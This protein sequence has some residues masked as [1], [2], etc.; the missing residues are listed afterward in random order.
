MNNKHIK[1][2]ST[3]L[4]IME[5]QI[6]STMIH[7]FTFTRLAIIKM[8]NVGKDVEKLEPCDAAGGNV[9]LC[10]AVENNLAILQRA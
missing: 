1:R 10:S 6:K 9:K 7:C 4:A 8:T 5:M 3:L 2:C